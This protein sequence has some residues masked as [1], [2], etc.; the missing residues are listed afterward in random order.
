M[1]LPDIT[2]VDADTAIRGPVKIRL[3][4]ET[5][6]SERFTYADGITFG[7]WSA[8]EANVRPM[9]GQP[10]GVWTVRNSAIHAGT[11]WF[12]T[13]DVAIEAARLLAAAVPHVRF[14]T[15]DERRAFGEYF[16]PI[17]AK[18]REQAGRARPPVSARPFLV[19]I[20][21][22]THFVVFAESQDAAD[23]ALGNMTRRDIE[24]RLEDIWADVTIETDSHAH[25]VCLTAEVEFYESGAH[26]E[27][28]DLVFAHDGRLWRPDVCP[29]QLYLDPRCAMRG[30]GADCPAR[31]RTSS[32][33]PAEPGPCNCNVRCFPAAPAV[34]ACAEIPASGA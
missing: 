2:P 30:H 5:V 19:K 13:Q 31:E 18:V 1:T 9:Y 11:G 14:E 33:G 28:D 27:D 22:V 21:K 32:F 20:E 16:K 7:E 34:G 4:A 6:G 8:V 17:A 15:A 12:M 26:M 3:D 23:T 10:G 24:D 25:R 29:V